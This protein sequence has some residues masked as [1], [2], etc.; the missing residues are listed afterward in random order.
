[1]LS[2][3]TIA[4][5]RRLFYAEHWKVGTIAAELGVHH[6]AVSR[7]IGTDSFVSRG[8]VRPSALDPYI[9]FIRQ[10]LEK[11]PRLRATRIHRML[12][13]RGYPGSARQVRHRIRQLGLRPQPKAYLRLE[14]ARGEQAQV[15]WAHIGKLEVGRTRRAVYAFVMVLSWSRAVFVDFSFDM[16]S[17]AVVRGHV[18]AF[19]AFGGVPR[20]CLYD[21]MKTVVVE[22]IGDVMRFHP[23]LLELS[24]HYHFAPRVCRPYRGNE[25]GR[26]ERAIRYLRQSFLAAREFTDLD[27]L[28]RQ[29]TRWRDTVAHPRPCPQNTDIS[30]EDAWQQER[31]YLLPLPEKPLHGTD[32]R[33][34]CARKQPYVQFDKNLYSIPHGLVGRPLSL[35]ASD[36]TIT[37]FDGDVEVACHQRAFDRRQIIEAPDHIE[38]LRRYKK[39]S[40]HAA[41]RSRLMMAAPATEQLYAELARRDEPIGPQT[42]A[43][44]LLLER[45]GAEQMQAAVLLALERGTPRAVSIEHILTQNARRDAAAPNRPLQLPKDRP[46]LADDSVINHDLEGYDDLV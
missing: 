37:I 2:K 21:N 10:T 5:I 19:Q 9:D 45:Y 43:L 12:V 23:R 39:A 35:V 22:R 7:A 16:T 13:D 6:D 41:G 4:E 29:F 20:Q 28:R 18:R 40:R 27:D 34:V 14:M 31:E 11:H 44:G 15:D 33:A 3:E 42:R 17:A 30:V 26:V 36:R 1:M 24:A 32:V 25:K 46:E 38:D 8:A